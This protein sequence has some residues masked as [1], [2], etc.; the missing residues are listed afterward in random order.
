MTEKEIINYISN[1]KDFLKEFHNIYYNIQRNFL[2]GYSLKDY[3]ITSYVSFNKIKDFNNYNLFKHKYL[4]QINSDMEIATEL[5]EAY[6]NCFLE[7][8]EEYLTP[9]KQKYNKNDSDIQIAYQIKTIWQFYS[10]FYNEHCLVKAINNNSN[11]YNVYDRKDKHLLDNNLAIDMEI[12]DKNNNIMAIQCKQLSYVNLDN[13]KKKVHLNKHKAYR[14]RFHN[15][16]YYV[17]FKDNAPWYYSTN[18]VKSYL[19]AT[20]DISHVS[21]KNFYT[22]TFE[23]LI[24][25]LDNN[26]LEVKQ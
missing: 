12:I 10:G 6:Y 15:T 13:A 26:N 17:L 4:L 22:G 14:E 23:D 7:N 5:Y 3:M 24:I 18:N 9:L 8:M 19:I 25:W 1:N 20:C 11:S 16:T 21:I 2:T